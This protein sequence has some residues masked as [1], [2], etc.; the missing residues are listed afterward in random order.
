MT[1]A[2][3]SNDGWTEIEKHLSPCKERGYDKTDD[4]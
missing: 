4:L 2:N 3:S 1:W